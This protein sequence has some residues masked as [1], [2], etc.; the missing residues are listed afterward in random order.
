ME[1]SLSPQDRKFLARAVDL[2]QNGWG[3]V[4]PNPLVGCVVVKDGEVVGEGWHEEYGG[5]HAEV[6]ALRQAG[7]RAS[8]A[9]AYI[10]LE[11][12]NHRGKTPPCS[13]ALLKA[14]ISRVLYASPDPGLTSGGGAEALRR[15]GVDAVGPILL[16]HESRRQNPAWYHNQVLEATFVGLKLAQTLDG[17]IAERAGRRT[18]ITGAPALHEAQRLRAGFDA[19][20]VGS[21]TA[22]ADDPL[23]TVREPVPMRKPPIRIVLDTGCDLSPRA[24]LFQD[25]PIAPLVVFTGEDASELAIEDLEDA[26]A[27]VHPVRRNATGLSLDAVLAICWETGIRSVLCEGGG[28]LAW[29]LI[30]GGHAQRLY[31]FVAP[32]VLGEKGVPAFPGGGSRE[33]WDRWAP[34]SQPRAFGRDTLLIFDRTT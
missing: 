31:L 28:R 8:G 23:L 2:A 12:C 33:L 7:E 11:P 5:P 15:A 27:T 20:M 26:G 18:P 30:K 16:P 22:T 6:H 13:E 1:T 9:T 21:G 3:R 24:R 10:S 19:V 25:I 14:G 17:K 34:A 4:H 29:S 32:F